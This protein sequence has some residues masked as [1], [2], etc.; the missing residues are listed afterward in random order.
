MHPYTHYS[1]WF[2]MQK[3]FTLEKPIQLSPVTEVA[4]PSNI[5]I[6][7]LHVIAA[8][9]L[10]QIPNKLHAHI[11]ISHQALH[12]PPTHVIIAMCYKG[13]LQSRKYVR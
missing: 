3:P 6:I 8:S 13:P 12:L 11:F 5:S 10:S 2:Q 4:N 7:R 9:R 1:R